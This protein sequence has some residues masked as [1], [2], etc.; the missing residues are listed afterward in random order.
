MDNQTRD[1]ERSAVIAEIS[2]AFQRVRLD[3]GITLHQAR[4]LDNWEPDEAA[5]AMRM[6]DTESH[7]SEVPD[8][9][10]RCFNNVL[11]FLDGKG[12]VFYIPAFMI[13]VL[14]HLDDTTGEHRDLGWSTVYSITNGGTRSRLLN[15]DQA[16][17][18]CRFLQYLARH[19]KDWQSEAQK[20]LDL[21][22]G[23]FNSGESESK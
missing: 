17:S 4:A 1:I 19:F 9:K 13:W 18:V 11:N 21:C 7:W 20:A 3:D 14:R 23:R 10:L 22:W 8:E 6:K 5:A 12:W 16:Q 2:T 15:A